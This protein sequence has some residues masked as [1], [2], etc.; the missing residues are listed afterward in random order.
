M[1]LRCCLSRFA[2]PVAFGDTP[3]GSGRRHP[4]GCRLGPGGHVLLPPASDRHRTTIPFQACICCAL[5]AASALVTLLELA[6][7]ER[8]VWC[9]TFH[10][11]GRRDCV[12]VNS[13]LGGPPP[14]SSGVAAYTAIPPKVLPRAHGAVTLNSVVGCGAYEARKGEMDVARRGAAGPVGVPRNRLAA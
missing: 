12:S 11:S 13:L 10:S 9:L 3:L 1:L 5:R 6:Q 8:N 7:A 2:G 14:L 4:F